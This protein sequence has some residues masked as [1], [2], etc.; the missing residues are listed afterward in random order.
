MTYYG[1]DSEEDS[2]EELW[3]WTEEQVYADLDREREQE[4][5]TDPDALPTWRVETKGDVLAAAVFLTA[6]AG[7]VALWVGRLAGKW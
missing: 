2:M 6:M 5:N 4:Q 7:L 3:A 1:Y